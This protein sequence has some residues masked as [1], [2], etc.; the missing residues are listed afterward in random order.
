MTYFK[1]FYLFVLNIF[2]YNNNKRGNTINVKKWF[3]SYLEVEM[4]NFDIAKTLSR[5][6]GV[7][8]V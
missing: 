7:L 8:S 1:M 5:P 2:D 6:D 3:T 4:F